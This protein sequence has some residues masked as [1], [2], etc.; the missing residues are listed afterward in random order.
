MRE[1]IEQEAFFYHYQFNES[2]AKE[3]SLLLFVKGLSMEEG[4]T[5]TKA[6]QELTDL[7]A[8]E[9][10]EEGKEMTYEVTKRVVEDIFK[11]LWLLLR[12]TIPEV[13]V[14]SKSLQVLIQV[15]N[16]FPVFILEPE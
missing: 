1:G 9:S 8:K 10:K 12:V 7:L 5:L 13:P 16:V 4:K 14:A 2:K 11:R 6:T 15:P 3:L